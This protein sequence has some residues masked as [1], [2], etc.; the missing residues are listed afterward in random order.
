M[1]KKPYYLGLSKVKTSDKYVIWY[2][3]SLVVTKMACQKNY[4]AWL[5]NFMGHFGTFFVKND[6]FDQ[7]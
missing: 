1:S 2:L 4:H 6:D 7:K 3:G 5:L